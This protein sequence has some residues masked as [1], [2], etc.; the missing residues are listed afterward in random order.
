VRRVRT[1]AVVNALRYPIWWYLTYFH[2]AGHAV[3]ALRRVRPVNEIYI[4]PL[5]GFTCHGS[6]D[7][8]DGSE[9]MQFIIS[10]GPWAEVRAL[11]TIAGI[12][13]DAHDASGRDFAD[14]WRDFFRKNFD[15]WRG[16]HQAL[17]H[18]V[19]QDDHRKVLEA[20]FTDGEVSP[21]PY[22]CLPDGGWDALPEDLWSEVRQLSLRMLEAE[23]MIEVG[24][25]Q[26]P[27]YRVEPMRWRRRHWQPSQ[28]DHQ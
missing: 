28:S 10:A 22:E 9:D 25:G 8:D 27:L 16:Y 7:T 6:A 13:R 23:E 3:A 19:S 12:D 21:P 15:D 18:E 14:K 17:G 1:D 4:H 26:P 24:H 20:Y 5:N 11:W 2:E